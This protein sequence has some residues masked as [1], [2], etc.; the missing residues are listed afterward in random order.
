MTKVKVTIVARLWAVLLALVIILSANAPA[1]A[2]CSLVCND[3]VTIALDDDCQVEVEPDMI[4]EGGGCPNGNLVV[5][6]K[7]N[8]A[9]VPAVVTSSHLN[10][11]I[12][13]RVRDLVS[14]NYCWGYIHVEDNLAPQMVCTNITL[15]CG[16]TNYTP[17]YLE[18]DL[19]IAE[20]YPDVIENCGNYT[21]TH[22]DQFLTWVA[23]A[24]STAF[25]T[26]APTSAAPGLP[27]IRTATPPPA[28]N[29]SISSAKT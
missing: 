4:L 3:L 10:Q 7:I 12:Q 27:W 13:T 26:S 17:Q 21:T 28:R 18:S 6:M 25:P 15:V 23:T 14:G 16:I 19:G 24:R 5:E 9:W 29:S 8:G 22:L 11:T 1:N 20:A 2:Q